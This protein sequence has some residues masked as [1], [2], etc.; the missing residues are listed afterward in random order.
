MK[1][2]AGQALLVAAAV[3]G[4]IALSGCLAL[5]KA[6]H[7]EVQVLDNRIVLIKPAG[8]LQRGGETV[9]KIDNYAQTPVNMELA[10]TTAPADRIPQKLVDAVT[11]RDDSRIVAITSRVD[12]VGT[13]LQYGAIPQ[14]SPR[15]VTMHVYLK[16]GKRYLLF[17]KLG[18]YAR[19]VVL[20]LVAPRS[21]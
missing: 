1:R 19:G 7:V 18:G 14:P 20:V 5:R 4:A 9:L 16:P 15:V 10:E 6:A 2:L 21:T 11:P 8:G 13:S 17:D 3:A 12:K